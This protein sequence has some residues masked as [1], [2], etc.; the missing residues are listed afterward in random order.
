[1]GTEGKKERCK[2]YNSEDINL[3]DFVYLGV[4]GCIDIEPI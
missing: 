3:L 1:M 2:V 4:W